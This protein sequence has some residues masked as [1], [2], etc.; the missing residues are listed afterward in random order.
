MV[1]AP[2]VALVVILED[3]VTVAY[4]QNA[5]DGGEGFLHVV[6]DL[7]EGLHPSTHSGE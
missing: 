4:D 5:L 6:I 1:V 2:I 3:Y 7:G